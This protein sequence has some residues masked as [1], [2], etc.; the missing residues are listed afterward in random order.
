MKPR[1]KI[2]IAALLSA[3]VFSLPLFASNNSAETDTSQQRA[4]IHFADLGGIKN[5]RA[6]GNDAIE[7][8]SRSGDW[9]HVEFWNH[10][11]GLR[12]ANS[13]AF[14][15]EPNGDLDRYSS[16]YV[17]RGESCQF[18]TFERMDVTEDQTQN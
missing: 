16:I 13:I 3:L 18:R 10:C 5:W 6:L 11:Y 7:I 1:L 4:V 12:S 17:G 2:S 9:Y 14:V 15:T 8:E